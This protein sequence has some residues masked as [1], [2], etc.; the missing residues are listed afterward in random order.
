MS[1]IPV[2]HSIQ[3]TSTTAAPTDNKRSAFEEED[4]EDEEEDAKH[5]LKNSQEAIDAAISHLE[6]VTN[7]Q[8]P[9][10]I[11]EINSRTSTVKNTQ[12]KIKLTL[13]ELVIE[14]ILEN[15]QLFI[16]FFVMM[17]A[18]LIILP[19]SWH[20]FVITLTAG[21]IAGIGVAVGWLW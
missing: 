17:V 14:M 18:Y 3:Y 21:L 2:S 11:E 1:T 8:E 7:T 5:T 16:P 4:E 9:R 6:Q 10:V 20:Y 13:T 15:K 12:E 19:R